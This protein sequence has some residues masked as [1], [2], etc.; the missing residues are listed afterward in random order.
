MSF[1]IR[2]G[3]IGYGSMGS[4]LLQGF[5]NAGAIM[6]QEIIVSTRTKSKLEEINNTW[7]GINIAASNAETSEKAKYIFL[8]V[9]PDDVKSILLDIKDTLTADS[10][11]VSAA[12]SVSISNIESVTHGKVI[13]FMP[14]V[15]S[16]VREG[17][18]LFCCNGQTGADEASYVENLLEAVSKV[19]IIPEADFDIA[20]V[21]TSCGPG[22]FA[23]ILDEFVSSALRAD[24]ALGRNDAEDMVI[25]TFFGTAKTLLEKNMGFDDMVKRVATKG[26]TTEEGVKV[27]RGELPDV[28]DHMFEACLRK[29]KAAAE[30]HDMEFKNI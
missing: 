6:P 26:G 9:E 12:G 21:L 2:V 24:S 19:R 8:C 14:T 10:V 29:R 13:R 11:I 15:T 17:I 4:M 25:A 23:A 20:T 28:F 27:F 30:K 3:F 22:L 16:E 18:T 1:M 5:I 7:P